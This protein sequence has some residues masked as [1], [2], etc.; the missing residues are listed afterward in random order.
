MTCNTLCVAAYTSVGECV[1]QTFKHSGIRGPFQG[2]F[3]T[4]VRNTPA[5]SIYLGSFEVLKNQ[6][7]ASRGCSVAELPAPIVLGAAGF[8]GI[9]YWCAIYPVDVCKSAI[10]TVSLSPAFVFL[11]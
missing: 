3:T 4:I 10:M 11:L 7:A 5:N 9:L 2:L 8:G 1:K 6:A